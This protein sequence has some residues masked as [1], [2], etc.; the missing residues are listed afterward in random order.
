M[1][2]RV[3][4]TEEFLSDIDN[5]VDYLLGQ[6]ASTETI[7]RWYRAVFDRLDDLDEMPKRLPVDE[8][9][10]ELNGYEVRKLNHKN[11]LAFYTI[12]DETRCVN[13]V[14]WQHGAKL[15]RRFGSGE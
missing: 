4:Y 15:R 7:A 11:Y 1:K 13:L 14:K 6:G 12:D 10:S 8:R 3:V 5:H 9:Q 2:Y